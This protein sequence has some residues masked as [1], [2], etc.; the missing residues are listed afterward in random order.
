MRALVVTA[1]AIALG[2][3]AAV[4]ADPRADTSRAYSLAIADGDVGTAS[5]LYA[6]KVKVHDLQFDD[7]A[8]DEAFGGAKPHTVSRKQ[9]AKLAA[10]F[11]GQHGWREGNLT[12]HVGGT[13]PRVDEIWVERTEVD[14]N[15]AEGADAVVDPTAGG[16]GVGPPPPPRPTIEPDVL[17]P[18]RIKGDARIL[19]GAATKKA[20][21][22]SKKKQ[23]TATYELCIDR[24]GA[25]AQVIQLASS[26]VASYDATIDAAMHGWGFKPYVV[27][28]EA[29]P[30]CTAVTFVYAQK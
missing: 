7:P 25:V 23:I 2:I 8:C 3:P 18:L 11:I 26:G 10:C 14:P 16:A 4:A 13:P 30:V 15:E 20:I 22:K 17:E 27:A 9:H 6:A 29:Q 19:P 1:A 28:G 5:K 24:T 12:Y 21:K